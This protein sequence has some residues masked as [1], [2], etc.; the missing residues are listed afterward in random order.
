[1]TREETYQHLLDRGMLPAL[2]NLSI[3][4]GVVSFPLY[5]F[6]GKQVGYQEYR[7]FAPRNS[8]NVREARYFT[9]LPRKVNGYFGTES[10]EYS[11]SLYVVEGVFKAAK[12]HRLGEPAVALMGSETERH[13]EQLRLLRRPYIAI[14]DNDGPG[15]KFAQNLGGFVS[16]RDLDEMTDEEVEELLDAHHNSGR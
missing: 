3:D 11:G 16:P 1:M 7:P 5:N 13:L 14:G 12:L 2:Y 6:G 8:A 15:A 9:Y 4:A 10:L